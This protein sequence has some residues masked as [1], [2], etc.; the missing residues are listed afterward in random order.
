MEYVAGGNLSQQISTGMEFGK[1]ANLAN[2][3]LSALVFLHDQGVL[4]RDIKPANILCVTP[5][6]YKLA[7]F[8]VSKEVAPSLSRQG[9][10]E[11]MAPEVFD[12]APYSFTADIWSLG[13]VLLE[14]M[15]GLPDGHPG[16]GRKWYKELFAILL[17]YHRQ[18]VQI[19]AEGDA[20]DFIRFVKTALLQLKPDKRLS[21][22]KCLEDYQELLQRLA[23]NIDLDAGSGANTPTQAHPHGSFRT[24][25]L[26]ASEDNDAGEETSRTAQSNDGGTP[27]EGREYR[28]EDRPTMTSFDKARDL[29][30]GSLASPTPSIGERKLHDSRSFPFTPASI[31]EERIYDPANVIPWPTSS[32]KG[33]L[34][35]PGRVISSIP[36]TSSV[37]DAS[38]K[39]RRDSDASAKDVEEDGSVTPR[40]RAPYHPGNE[41]AS[42][43]LGY[44]LDYHPP[45]RMGES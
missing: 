4:H 17:A 25:S 19:L 18:C 42:P 16:N 38:T 31:V 43:G 26:E 8:G 11:Y 21:A 33:V 45:R 7:D 3:I 2:Q 40:R 34:Y 12:L 37:S 41:A 27:E 15:A 22:R 14:C 30:L 39:S 29:L 35:D 6:H 23:H 13:V 28:N 36:S 20:L 9:T 10:T 32:A 44:G 1:I 24:N 5:D